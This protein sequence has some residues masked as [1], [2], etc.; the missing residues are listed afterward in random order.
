[1]NPD[2]AL[3]YRESRIEHIAADYARQLAEWG[4]L[5]REPEGDIELSIDDNG[6]VWADI[7]CVTVQPS[8]LIEL[9]PRQNVTTDSFDLLRG[10]G[11]IV[12]T[13]PPS[14]ETGWLRDGAGWA[15]TI[16][17]TATGAFI[18]GTALPGAA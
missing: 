2:T 7:G 14:T 16:T 12:V 10:F 6:K 13:D 4:I 1:M 11:A 8:G 3:G 5:L 17:T 15:I 9:W 18:V